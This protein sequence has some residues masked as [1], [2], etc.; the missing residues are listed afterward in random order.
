[1]TDQVPDAEGAAPTPALAGSGASEI[2]EAR[3]RLSGAIST[4]DKLRHD[5]DAYKLQT[6]QEKDGFT[7]QL[8]KAQDDLAALT[9]A[10]AAVETQLSDVTTKHGDSLAELARWECADKEPWLR[11]Y[12]PLLPKTADPEALKR[13]VE[14]IQ[15]ARNQDLG[16]MRQQM[17]NQPPAP[18]VPAAPLGRD[19][20]QAEMVKFAG[21][22]ERMKE[23]YA[24]WDALITKK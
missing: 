6:A 17:Q 1:M 16:S 21:N 7:A 24:Q 12:R 19:A 11:P 13:A 9:A 10:K 2:E 18:A 20:L 23:F 14:A 22:P 8:A 5:F 15:A 4:L 3:R